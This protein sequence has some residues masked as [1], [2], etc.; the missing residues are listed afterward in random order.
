MGK[1][2]VINI[3]INTEAVFADY[4]YNGKPLLDDSLVEKMQMIANVKPIRQNVTFRFMKKPDIAINRTKFNYAFDNSINN[5]ISTKQH[6]I[7]R[8]LITGVILL[9]ISLALI[10][11]ENFVMVKLGAIVSEISNIV[12]WVFLWVTVEIMTIQ[13][14]QLI[15]DKNKLKRIK[16]ARVVIEDQK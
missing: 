15:I 12:S 6:E 10:F 13:L 2:N 4:G 14:I 9:F 5:L 8:C 16:N 1:E 7:N 11:I 3:D